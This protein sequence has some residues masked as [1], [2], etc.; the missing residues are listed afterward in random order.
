M[1]MS[2]DVL[3]DRP[4]LVFRWLLRFDSVR[5]QFEVF[6]IFADSSIRGQVLPGP[7]HDVIRLTDI[8]DV[9]RLALPFFSLGIMV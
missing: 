3:F 5:T 4:R 2:D 8:N 7:V 1:V 9:M 6:P